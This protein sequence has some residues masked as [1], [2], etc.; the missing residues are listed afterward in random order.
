MTDS[1]TQLGCEQVLQ[2]LMAM[3]TNLVQKL[4]YYQ[5]IQYLC[6]ILLMR[7][8]MVRSGIIQTT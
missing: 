6:Y 7:V 1:Q 4:W 2:L 8:Y 3:E 5:M